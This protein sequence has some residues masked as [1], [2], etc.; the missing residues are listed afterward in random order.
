MANELVTVQHSCDGLL[1]FIL[2]KDMVTVDLE[3]M[4]LTGAHIYKQ[5]K[6]NKKMILPLEQKIYLLQ[7]FGKGERDP[8]TGDKRIFEYITESKPR[9][10]L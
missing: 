4:T 6:N 2:P 3:V 9:A 8:M 10:K 7:N 1:K 5:H